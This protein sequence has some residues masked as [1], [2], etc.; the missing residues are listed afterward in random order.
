M[1]VAA[2][3][4]SRKV[5]VTQASTRNAFV[6]TYALGTMGVPVHC[7]D[8]ERYPLSRYSRFCR[9]F[10][11]YPSPHTNPDDYFAALNLI[12]DREKIALLFPAY[13]EMIF[14]AQN[15]NRL[16]RPEVLI[17]PPG[18]QVAMLHKKTE[19]YRLCDQIGCN[20]PQTMEL[21]EAADV[22]RIIDCMPFPLVLKPERGGGGWGVSFV[23]SAETLRQQW[24]AFDMEKHRNRLFAQQYVQG[25]LFGYGVLC[26]KGKILASNCYHTVRQHPIGRGT[27][28]FRRGC[29]VEDIEH[30]VERIL[31]HLG[32]T[33]VCQFDFLQNVQDG[34]AYLI[35]ANPRFWGSLAQ[36]LA[37]GINFPFLAYLLGTRQ[38]D[39]SVVRRTGAQVTSSWL[40]GDL[41]VLLTRLGSD[42]GR[43]K[44]M[45]EHI[46]S[47][48]GAYFDDFRLDD[49]LPFFFYPLQKLFADRGNEEAGG[50]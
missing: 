2:Y 25:P 18:E 38:H 6:L 34:K 14:L 24:Q 27:P 9:G 32:W 36:G 48:K 3:D 44:I 33:G 4:C 42:S 46:A 19:L 47:W 11:R 45:K 13:D 22:E 20:A 16:A 43:L 26:D 21:A 35:D 50:F 5:L 29:V 39:G 23:T 12:L 17:A 37:C 49:P 15:R 8:V 41:R 1:V 31:S 30:Q 7:A 28:S 10:S 40:W